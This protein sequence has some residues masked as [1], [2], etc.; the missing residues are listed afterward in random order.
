MLTWTCGK[1]FTY[2]IKYGNGKPPVLIGK[3]TGNASKERGASIIP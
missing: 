3:S 1:G 2:Q